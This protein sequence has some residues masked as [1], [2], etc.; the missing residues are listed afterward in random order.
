MPDGGEMKTIALL[1]A[2][3]LSGCATPYQSSGARGGFSDVQLDTNVF[4]ITFKGNGFT[5]ASDVS[6]MALLRGSELSL[7]HGFPYF[8]VVANS[9]ITRTALMQT[10]A[11]ANTT[12]TGYGTPV[13]RSNTVI[14]GG[15][16]FAVAHPGAMTTIVC[17]EKK[18]EGTF[19]YNA[20]SIFDSLSKTYMK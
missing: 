11:Y 2:V 10:P 20:Q 1:M 9:D 19:A 16:T 3:L 6:N 12:T 13:L 14:T 15:Q 8:I 5:S 7:K 4:Q 18:P 17:L